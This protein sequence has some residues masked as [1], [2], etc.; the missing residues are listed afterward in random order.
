VVSDTEVTAC[1]A[2]GM[3]PNATYTVTV[4]TPN[5]TSVPTGWLPTQV[6]TSSLTY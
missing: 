2:I 5:G 6:S 3:T 4:T 1:G